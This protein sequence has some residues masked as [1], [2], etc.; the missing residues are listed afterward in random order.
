MAAVVGCPRQPGPGGGEAGCGGAV[1]ATIR[2]TTPVAVLADGW[3]YAGW[4][5][6]ASH[7]RAVQADWP[8]VASRLYH[9]SV[10]WP[11]R[12]EDDTQVEQVEPGRRLV[13]LT[14]SGAL[15][16]ARVKHLLRTGR[17]RRRAPL[18][19]TRHHGL[20]WGGASSWPPANNPVRHPRERETHTHADEGVNQ[21]QDRLLP[22][23][24]AVSE[25][26]DDHDHGDGDAGGDGVLRAA[27]EGN[28]DHSEPHEHREPHPP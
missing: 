26:R 16:H 20:E 19:G 14:H 17:P 25:P 8:A 28:D 23:D 10:T 21:A 15:G 24:R 27:D 5:V 9:A 4:V 2:A 11:L 1:T 13:L 18:A 7:V 22:R 12:M 3:A 6:G